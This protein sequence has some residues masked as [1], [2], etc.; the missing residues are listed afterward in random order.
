MR[1][2][3]EYILLFSFRKRELSKKKQNNTFTA[4]MPVQANIFLS[5]H[6]NESLYFHP[7]KQ[8]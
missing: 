5:K 7:I 8:N 4:N 6:K 1:Y 2:R 3:T